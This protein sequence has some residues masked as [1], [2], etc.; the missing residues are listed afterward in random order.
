[1]TALL[2]LV[3]TAAALNVGEIRADAIY[4]LSALDQQL[5]LGKAALRKA[6]REGLTVRRIGRKSYVIGSELIEWVKKFGRPV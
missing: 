2:L 5:G 1:M 6:R 3:M 4:T